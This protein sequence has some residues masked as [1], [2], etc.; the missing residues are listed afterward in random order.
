MTVLF[1]AGFLGGIA[2]I[3]LCGDT[4]LKESHVL[5]EESLRMA[6][7]A[8]IDAR[9]LFVRLFLLRGKWLLLLWLL[10][11]TV[12]ALPAL[13]IALAWL[14]FS[15]GAFISLFVIR[16]RL[17]GVLLFLASVL[18]QI[19]LYAPLVWILGRA[20]Y[21]KGM[22]RFRKGEVFGSRRT[23]RDYMRTAAVCLAI[24]LL[25]LALESSVNPLLLR[26]V[27]NYF[28]A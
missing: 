4:Y 21:E 18:P 16:M 28:F 20:V 8:Q 13:L 7:N 12:A 26:A 19:L 10:G 1:F 22:E 15:M 25:G 11:Y 2:F 9:A 5:G 27:V 24:L 14:G 23:E 6:A 3:Y 17:M